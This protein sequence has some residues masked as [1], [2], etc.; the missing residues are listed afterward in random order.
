M[1]KLVLLLSAA[2]LTACAAVPPPPPPIVGRPDDRVPGYST[3]DARALAEREVRQVLGEAA[4]AE[5]A[6][7]RTAVFVRRGVSLPRMTRQPDGTWKP[8][9]PYANAAIRTSQGWIG[10]PGGVRSLLAPETGR[11]LDRLLALPA[12]WSEPPLPNAGCTDPGGLTSVIRH[13]GREHIATH[14]CGDVG[15]T[16]QV[17]SIVMASRIVDWTTVPPAGIPAGITIQ[18]FPDR[19]EQYFRYSGG[20]TNPANFVISQQAEWEAIWRRIV[21][22]NGTKPPAP[23]VDFSR[24]MLLVAA[25]GTQPTGGYTIHID[26][27]LENETY[28]E[29]LI[30][31]TSPGP[32]CGATA[33]LTNPVDV[34]RVPISTKAVR[35]SMRDV[36]T[37]CP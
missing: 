29:V 1:N 34:V 26:R 3:A 16:G 15:L 25:M 5:I 21:A 18:R 30:T 14:P 13:N 19:V 4:W 11:E 22:N 35:W 17:A 24:E 31:R 36:Q 8:E 10:W 28:L 33:A 27:V 7:A 37:V 9:G 23:T 20:L 12:L 32:R 6:A 2:A